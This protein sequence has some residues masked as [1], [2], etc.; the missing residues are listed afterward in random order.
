MK[1]K[2]Y[3]LGMVVA[4][5]A[6]MTLCA[7]EARAASARPVVLVSDLH[8]GAGHGRD[9]R[10]NN[11]EDFR[12]QSDFNAFLDRISAQAK[13]QADL[14]LLGDVFELWQ[15]PSMECSTDLSKPSCKITDCKAP[16]KDLGC[17]EKDAVER[18]RLVLAQ[19]G[20]FIAAIRAFAQKGRN[21]VVFVP[22]NHDAALLFPAV[23]KVLTDALQ[24]SRVTVADGGYWVS[25]DGA[26][27]AD[28]GH[29][30]DELNKFSQWPKPFTKLGNVAYLQKAWGENMV[31]EFYNQ[32]ESVFPIID[33]LSDEKSG[34]GYAVKHAGSFGSSC[35]S[36][37]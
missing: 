24:S 15:S 11:I 18:L 12:W 6:S 5:M 25:P 7:G 16:S 17:A 2:L 29:Q 35:S 36:S 10:W 31:Q 4:A 27:Y 21:T 8:V 23:R 22:G 1:M 30:F 19:H 9:G 3:L 14:V 33:N 13:D 20:D 26:V 32:Y 37:R 28:H 34:V